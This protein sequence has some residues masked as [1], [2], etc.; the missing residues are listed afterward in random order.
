MNAQCDGQA[1]CSRCSIRGEVHCAY[2]IHVKHQ[3]EEMVKQIR[4]FAAHEQLTRKI[5]SAIA[6]RSEQTPKIIQL[7]QE[8]EP[9]ATIVQSMSGSAYGSPDMLMEDRF[10]PR[11][12]T[13]QHSAVGSPSQE[14]TGAFEGF[15]WTTVTPD[16][17]IFEHLFSLY[18]SWVHPVHT[19]FKEGAFVDSYRNN[20]EMHCSHVL[21][22]AICAVACQMHTKQASLESHVDYGIL[23]KLFMDAARAMVRPEAEDLTTVQALGIMFLVDYSHGRGLRASMYLRIATKILSRMKSPI[24][25]YSLENSF[26]V[27][28]C[29]IQNLNV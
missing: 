27:T 18:F 19:L 6:S 25:D 14:A 3:K 13:Y 16:P 15:Q 20:S 4:D 11:P 24:Q 28:L 10:S 17:K 7:L 8:G 26:N 1:P 29:G 5:L 21:V 9:L 2:E 23:G 12:S 22:N